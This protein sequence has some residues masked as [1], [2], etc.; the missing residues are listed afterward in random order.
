MAA[1]WANLVLASIDRWQGAVPDQ[2]LQASL[3]LIRLLMKE[4]PQLLQDPKDENKRE[5]DPARREV[6]ERVEDSQLILEIYKPIL[7]MLDATLP[8][9]K[10]QP[11]TK[12]L[13]QAM[14]F[15]KE[16]HKLFE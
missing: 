11:R 4:Q 5:E 1:G 14:D 9:S 12:I 15:K 10:C 16:L 8:K 6:K 7:S 2:G 3:N 13:K